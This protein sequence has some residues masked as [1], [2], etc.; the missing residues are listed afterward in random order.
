MNL[1]IFGPPG[2]GKGTQSSF[3]AKKFK[4][5]QLS[6]GEILRNEIKNNTNLGK[7]IS[8]IINLG[9]LVSDELVVNLI[10]KYLSNKDY[11]NKIIFDGYPRNLIQAQT[12]NDLLIKYNQKIHIALRLTVSLDTIIKRIK[13]RSALEKRDDD[14]EEIAIKRYETYEKNI[15]PVIDFYKQSNLLKVVN[16]E[17]S[18][19]QINNE[20]SALIESI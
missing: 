20:I 16:G 17:S 8:S 6:T 2:A 13:E 4:L 9:N 19:V 3:I 10:E 18:I 15:K 11:K 12:L 1:V 7:Q 5:Y 14:S